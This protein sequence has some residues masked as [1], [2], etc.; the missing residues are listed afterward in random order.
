MSDDK[1]T[2]SENEKLTMAFLYC[3]GGALVLIPLGIVI[4]YIIKGCTS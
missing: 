1:D 2:R 4:A 3:Y